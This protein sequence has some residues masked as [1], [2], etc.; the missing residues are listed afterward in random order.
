MTWQ[1]LAELELWDLMNEAWDRM[2]I[3]Q[4]RLWE[5]IR[6]S[7]TKW[8]L[9]PWGDQGGGFWVI[10]VI[11][12][13]VLWYNDIENGFNRSKYSTIGTIDEYCCNQDE[14][15]WTVQ[16]ILKQI[17]TGEPPASGFEPP[18]PSEYE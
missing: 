18:I 5:Q 11:G 3:E 17:Q 8:K 1:P 10:A 9:D 7:P 12:N 6:V 13:T 2:S 16:F 14:L 4:R 15:E